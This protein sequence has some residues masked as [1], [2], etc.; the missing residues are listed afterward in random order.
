MVRMSP[1]HIQFTPPAWVVR[2]IYI[3]QLTRTKCMWIPLVRIKS[4][5]PPHVAD[6]SFWDNHPGFIVEIVARLGNNTIAHP[7]FCGKILRG[8]LH[9]WVPVEES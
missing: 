3:Q 5:A 1:Q 4:V 6:L 8:Q 9:L 2:Y 7:S